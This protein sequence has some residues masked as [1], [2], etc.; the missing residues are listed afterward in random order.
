MSLARTT[1][2]LGRGKISNHQPHTRS[3]SQL[4]YGEI[5]R[6]SNFFPKEVH[7]TWL[8]NTEW[9]ALKYCIHMT[10]YGL[11]RLYL[12]IYMF[13]YMH[14]YYVYTYIFMHVTTINKIN[15]YTF[16]HI[17]TINKKRS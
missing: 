6:N 3:S 9:S 11:S 5:V 1:V 2:D 4:K 7:I 17:N 8:S 13:V 12:G 10:L 14:L 16:L 15:I